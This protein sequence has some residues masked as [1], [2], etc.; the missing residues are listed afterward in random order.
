[1]STNEPTKK[2]MLVAAEEKKLA[3]KRRLESAIQP[4]SGG[5]SGWREHYASRPSDHQLQSCDFKKWLRPD[6]LPIEQACFVLLGFEPPPLHVLRFQQDTYNPSREPTWDEPPEFSDTLR[7][8]SLSIK[9]GNISAR[10]V[11]EYPYD[12]R[13]VAWP[14]LIRWARSK[15]YPIA[16]ELET[17]V[18][19]MEPATVDGTA[20]VTAPAVV[21]ST[22]AG[23]DQTRDPERRLALLRELGGSAKYVR[24]R[25]KFS[26]ITALV[27]RE[28][29]DGRKRRDEKTIRSDLKEAAQAERD[30]KSASVFNGLGQR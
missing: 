30:A 21:T 1:M 18:A 12:T 16:P 22:P 13:H 5:S 24:Y 26:G 7:S 15:N 9:L 11:T 17:I 3:D 28:K 14:D 10:R 23:A 2:T 27:K 19:E 20:T 25:W 8:L 29:A 6:S 4:T